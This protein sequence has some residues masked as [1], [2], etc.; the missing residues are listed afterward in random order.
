[1]KPCL[2]FLGLAG[3]FIALTPGLRGQQPV[4]LQE[5][6]PAVKTA[7]TLVISQQLDAFRSNDFTKAF[8]FAATELRKNLSPDIFELMVKANYP[9]LLRAVDTDFGAALDDGQEGVVF[10]RLTDAVGHR[11]IYQYNLKHEAAGWRIIGVERTLE[12]PPPKPP[13]SA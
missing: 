8:T 13:I 11:E 1:M 2:F 5:S 7:L 12:A 10:V 6:T 9:I 4:I 3:L